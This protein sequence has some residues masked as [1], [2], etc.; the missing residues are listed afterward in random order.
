MTIYTFASVRGEDF[1]IEGISP[2]DAYL[3]LLYREG[4]NG[5][6]MEVKR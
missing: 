5:S 4:G 2:E 3:N 6:S 1:E